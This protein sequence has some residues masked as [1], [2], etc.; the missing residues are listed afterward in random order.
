MPVIRRS[1]LAS[2]ALLAV[3]APVLAQQVDT[4]ARRLDRIDVV[5][6]RAGLAAPAGG[7]TRLDIDLK[8]LPA[9][10]SV[11]D[12]ALMDE[13]GVRSTQEALYGIP[14]LTVAAPPGNGNAVTYRGF[15][16]SQISQLFNGI[17]VQYA[18]IAA[19]PVDGWIY[20]RVEA[21]GG[22]SSFLHG[23]GAIG[24]AINYVTR[25]AQAGVDGGEAMASVGSF[26]S[27][28]V[29]VGGNRTLGGA[30]S[31]HALRV[32]VAHSATDGYVDRSE[33]ES[34]TAAASLRTQLTAALAHTLAVE[35]QIED[36]QRP[37]WGTPAVA[38]ADGRLQVLPGSAFRNYNVADGH[39]GQDVTWVRSLTEWQA[40]A[41]ARLGNTLY[42]YDAL[43]D[44]RNVETY[45]PGADGGVERS[46]ALL[47]RH[48]QEVFGDRLEWLQAGR[49]GA[50]PTQWSL[51]LDVAF[52]R[53]T[54]FPRSVSGTL[55][56]VPV[57]AVTPGN[58][59]DVPGM[60]P[61][62]EPDRTNRLHSQA[63]F[64]ENLTEL[65]PRLSLLTGLRHDRIDLDVVNHRAPSATNPARFDRRYSPTTGRAGLSF[66][67]TPAANLY[68]QVATAADP[69]AGILSTANLGT[70]QDFDLT[71]G[72]QVEAGAKVDLG[73]R[74]WA[75][76]AG[77]RIVRED[78]AIA[79]PDNPGQTLPVGQQSARGVE[80][81]FSLQAHPR[82]RIDGNLAWV[83]ASL[84]EF[85]QTID[86][87]SVSLAGNRPSNTPARVGNLWLR[88][89]L[90]P[91]WSLGM[92]A[93]AVSARFADQANTLEV[94]GYTVLGADLRWQASAATSLTLR[95]RNLGD[96]TYAQYVTGTPML[97]LG[98]PRTLEL[99]LRTAF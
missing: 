93:R 24:G 31:G 79:D 35:H 23:V 65:S 56:T 75:T 84:D 42:H 97:Y 88:W 68:A 92:D 72:R 19:R 47:Q 63:L 76:L 27:Q 43:R 29:A 71:T 15:S 9:S 14:G 91:D 44:Y 45:R 94:G 66:A 95:G 46:G 7:G 33:R 21:I 22:P 74:G 34:W 53:Q 98:E 61:G 40:G 25:L 32:D 1:P 28:T 82:L 78:L 70:L 49:I 3:A 77:Y 20:D 54:R 37:Y 96:R 16:G 8:P 11:I 86:G 2:A 41:D 89:T 58:F 57:D 99:S 6:R 52:N 81:A 4:D 13:R 17:D 55:D 62:F 50:L 73:A 26:D 85:V 69:P 36:A 12:R 64:V 18:S 51:G 67:L 87:V 38:D 60:A 80:A 90:A 83:D 5:G 30:D 10:V 59:Y 39:Y 48:D